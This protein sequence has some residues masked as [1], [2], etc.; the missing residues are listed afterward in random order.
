MN[1][2]PISKCLFRDDFAGGVKWFRACLGLR[3]KFNCEQKR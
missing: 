3:P 2:E 1:T